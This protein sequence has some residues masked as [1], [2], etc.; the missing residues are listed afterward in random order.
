[1]ASSWLMMVIIVLVRKTVGSGSAPLLT[2]W[3]PTLLFPL[4]KTYALKQKGDQRLVS[5][6]LLEIT[7]PAENQ[8]KYFSVYVII[9]DINSPLV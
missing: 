7:L 3:C 1:M 6:G 4:M 9:H 8:V 5:S 2:L